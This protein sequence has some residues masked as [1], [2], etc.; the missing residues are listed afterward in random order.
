[1]AIDK[2][3]VYAIKTEMGV[4]VK[5]VLGNKEVSLALEAVNNR[6]H[7]GGRSDLI[8]YDNDP[9]KKVNDR[10]ARV[11]DQYL[12]Q[13]VSSDNT[14]YSPS[15]KDLKTILIN[16]FKERACTGKVGE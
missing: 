14:V 5:F 4:V 15:L 7:C 9:A 12:R 13:G 6:N 10:N 1:M 3:D 16:L 8:V 2:G 11:T